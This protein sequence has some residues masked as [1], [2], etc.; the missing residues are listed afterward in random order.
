MRSPRASH[1]SRPRP[2][3]PLQL[4]YRRLL[5]VLQGWGDGSARCSRVI[6][7]G[8]Q[9]PPLQSWRLARQA[10]RNTGAQEARTLFPR[11][12][13]PL[14]SLSKPTGALPRS[15]SA[16]T[17]KHGLNT[18]R[19]HSEEV[20]CPP[21]SPCHPDGARAGHARGSCLTALS[22]APCPSQAGC[23][24]FPQ[25]NERPMRHGAVGA[26]PRDDG[27]GRNHPLVSPG[28]HLLHKRK[29]PVVS[30]GHGEGN[31]VGYLVLT[32]KPRGR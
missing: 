32:Q 13:F 16:T 23:A 24:Q 29:G 20:V 30:G 19:G 1:V 6:N 5:R 3:S 28:N 8:P 17:G 10:S 27:V 18:G 2:P 31:Q 21:R 11:A 9:K 14:L 22:P 4:G 15:M 7:S 26:P 25:R 12:L